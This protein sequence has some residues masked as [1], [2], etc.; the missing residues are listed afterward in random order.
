MK[1]IWKHRWEHQQQHTRDERENL[2]CRRFD[3]EHQHNSQI[4]CKMQKDPNSKHPGN[5][6]HNKKTKPMDNRSR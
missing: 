4:K 1:E 3:R 2:R 5:P 6:G